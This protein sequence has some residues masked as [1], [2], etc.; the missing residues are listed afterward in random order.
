MNLNSFQLDAQERLKEI[1]KRSNL[2]AAFEIGGGPNEYGIKVSIGKYESW[3]HP[4]GAD[5]IGPDLDKRFEIYD[6]NS[7]DDLKVAYLEFVESIVGR[8]RT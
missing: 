7:L 6:F 3:I 5:V 2:N 4:D 8:L 1:F